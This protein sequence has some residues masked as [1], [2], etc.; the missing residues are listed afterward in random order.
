MWT[1]LAVFFLIIAIFF[2][3]KLWI[4]IY[5]NAFWI[6]VNKKIIFITL[7]VWAIAA[8]SILLFPKIASYFGVSS[9]TDNNYS[10]WILWYFLLY[11]NLLVWIISLFLKSFSRKQLINLLFFNVFFILLYAFFS[12]LNI[13]EFVLSVILYYLFVAYGE[14][15]IKNQLA[16]VIN[17]KIAKLDSDLLLYHILVA[18]G[19]A[20]W[21]NIVYL[22]WS[23]GFSTFIA[24]IVWGIS[25]VVMRWLLWFGAHT[26]YSSLVGMWNLLWF[27][28]IVFFILISMLVHY[29][30]DLALYFDYKFIIPLFMVVVYIWIS[31]IFYKID[32]LYIEV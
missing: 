26:F 29:G 12:H 8:F 25:I 21:E 23:I 27:F 28:S 1:Y 13:D 7:S 20:F 11:L 6:Q 18:I 4:W 5:K 2:T 9:F 16:F 15:F 24:T 32:R 31:Y 30:Y 10:W 17:N 3:A 14:E 22:T 19:F